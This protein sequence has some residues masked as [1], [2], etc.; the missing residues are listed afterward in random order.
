[1]LPCPVA[2]FFCSNGLGLE[3]GYRYM[4]LDYA[5]GSGILESTTE[6]LYG[7]VFWQF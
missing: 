3:M 2:D 6:G 4:E 7:G 1:L 5:V